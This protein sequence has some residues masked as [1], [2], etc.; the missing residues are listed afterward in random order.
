MPAWRV[1]LGDAVEAE[2]QLLEA[3]FDVSELELTSLTWR[4]EPS[5]AAGAVALVAAFH[6]DGIADVALHAPSCETEERAALHSAVDAELA[7][8]GSIS[9]AAVALASRLAEIQ[10]DAPLQAPPAQLQQ[11]AAVPTAAE[12]AL[13]RI[14]H[15]NDS[16][17]YLARLEEAILAVDG[18]SGRGFYRQSATR[19]T[20]VLLV[21]RGC[22]AS[23][24]AAHAAVDKVLKQ[25]RTEYMDIDR[26]GHKC[27]ERQSSVLHRG[28][29]RVASALD[30]PR[31]SHAAYVTHDELVTRL[32]TLG[33]DVCSRGV[34]EAEMRR[35]PA[36]R[37][38][39]DKE[40]AAAASANAVQRALL[41]CVRA[42]PGGAN[43]AAPVAVLV[44]CEVRPN[45]QRTEIAADPRTEASGGVLVV[46][47]AAP[48]RDG[49]ANKE[50]AEALAKWVG[51]SRAQV[52]V[53]AGMRSR[54]KV[55]RIAWDTDGLVAISE[56]LARAAA[57]ASSARR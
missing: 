30:G 52:T 16:K 24:A 10:L 37:E 38:A 36:G 7:V 21:V 45:K 48:P 26:A 33:G 31:F 11:T 18:I 14:D 2:R 27:K 34:L 12:T 50:L 15:M 43:A 42:E 56:R 22:A 46:D 1:S 8:G 40:L 35:R 55:V 28:S 47:L 20:D 39:S 32:S 23:E 9:S 44:E 49:L 41:P 57:T 53:T 51:A 17:G 54:R 13:V 4:V 29:E 3:M 5:A 19:A 25:L 6:S